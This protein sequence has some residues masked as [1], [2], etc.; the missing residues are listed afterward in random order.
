MRYRKWTLMGLI[1]S[2]CVLA[3][4]AWQS[5]LLDRS[6]AVAQQR[7]A[8]RVGIEA[9]GAPFA[10][11]EGGQVK[12]YAAD[13]AALVARG[14][15]L[16]V[17]WVVADRD[18]LSGK[19]AAYEIDMVVAD[20]VADAAQD[21]R[22]HL[23]GPY[24]HDPYVYVYPADREDAD[25]PTIARWEEDSPAGENDVL[26][27][28]WADALLTVDDGGADAALMPM[29]AAAGLLADKE[30]FAVVRASGEYAAYMM[31]MRKEDGHLDAA[32]DEVMDLLIKTG[33]FSDLQVKWYDILT[34]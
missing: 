3:G 9:A 15:G 27:P 1:L 13:A 12:G 29:S 23:V 4:C 19:L 26:C 32:V 14:L 21:R 24:F 10:Y 17:A 34:D 7:G 22:Y 28:T 5:D 16:D 25:F 30:G 8:L 18:A 11:E 6:L 33:A 20:T 2:V 31:V